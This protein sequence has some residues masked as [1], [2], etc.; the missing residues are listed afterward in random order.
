MA[1]SLSGTKQTYTGNWFHPEYILPI[2]LIKRPRMEQSL[3]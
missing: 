2:Y 1:D 3:K